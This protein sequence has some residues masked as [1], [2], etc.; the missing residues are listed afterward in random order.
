MSFPNKLT[1][2]MQKRGITA[3]EI[4]KQS[5]GN[6][7]VSNIRSF[8]KGT[9]LPKPNQ[10]R[11]LNHIFGVDFDLILN[12]SPKRIR[13]TSQLGISISEFGEVKAIG[14]PGKPV[15]S[16]K[17]KNSITR[18]HK[19]PKTDQLICGHCFFMD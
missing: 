15:K 18:I 10:I 12:P 9:A 11:L 1:E 7:S 14:K 4:A 3:Q 16:S 5:Y 8:Q 17:I 13:P 19:I 2:I 6:I